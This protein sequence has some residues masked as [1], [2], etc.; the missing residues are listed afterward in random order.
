MKNQIKSGVLYVIAT[1]IGNLADIS[2]R[3][4]ETLKVVDLLLAEDTRVTRKLLEHYGIKP[5][6][7]ISC[8][9]HNEASRVALIEQHLQNNEVVGLVSDAG[10][11]IISDPGFTIISTLQTCGFTVVAIPGPCALIT[12]LSIAG[13]KS[14]RF[15]FLGFLPAKPTQRIQVI[16]QLQHTTTTSIFYESTH[17]IMACLMDI[18]QILPERKIA[19]AK[20]LTKR[21]EKVINGY[22]HEIIAVLT[23]DPALSKGEFV[24]II[25]G[26]QQQPHK[27]LPEQQ[28]ILDILLQEKLPL[29]QAAKITSQLTGAKK[30]DVYKHALSLLNGDN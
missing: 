16:A 27:N 22:A 25:E 26:Q 23:Q 20:E 11:P 18:A 2:F 1:P 28:K 3:A 7:L 8:H 5:P 15:E 6:K 13:I 4:L 10:T 30:N 14:E 24:V 21:H 19:L 17:R 29:K 12:A 9:E